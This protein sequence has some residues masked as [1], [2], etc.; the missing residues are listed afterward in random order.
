MNELLR[1]ENLHVSAGGR[2]LLHGVD[3]TVRTGE[4]HVIMGVNGAGKSTLLH[5]VM[6]NPAYTV[7]EGCI[8]FNGEDITDLSVDKRARLGIFLSFQSPIS[9]AGISVENFIRTAK[10]AVSGQQQRLFP[11]KRLLKTRMEALDMDP[12]YASRYLNEGFSGGE[13]KKN[14][15]LQMRVLDPK[16]A[17]LDE[18]DSG[19]DVD[20]VRT[21]AKNISEFHNEGNALLLITHLNQLIRY[22]RPDHVHILIGGRIVKEGGPELADEVEANGFDAYRN[23]SGEA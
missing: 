12:S 6:G 9:V 7:T 16:L 22:I 13:R 15:I 5:A 19:L 14:E 3:L 11:F 8:Y 2:E 17:M 20:A 21:V 1:I 23:A 18:T 4:A 10:T